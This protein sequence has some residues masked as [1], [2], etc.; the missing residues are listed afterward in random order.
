MNEISARRLLFPLNPLY[1]LGL[2]F[3]ELSL[4]WPA[5]QL[6]HPVVSIGNLSTG[7]S[8]K[9]PLTIALA[10]ALERRGIRV[11]VLSRGYGREGFLPARVDSEGCA[12]EF[13]DEP[14]LIAREAEVP[15]Y[16]APRRYDA[17]LLAEAEFEA[18]PPQSQVEE[19]E[20]GA[21]ESALVHE[22]PEL[23]ADG[24]PPASAAEAA[25][26]LPLVHLLDDG[27]Q[28]RQLARDVDIL[29]LNSRD[30]QDWLLPAGNLREPLDAARRADVIAIPA[31][32]P[33]LEVALHLWGWEKPIW[34]LQRIMEV[35]DVAGPVA[36]FCGIARPEQFFTGLEAAGV[37]IAA[38]FAFP[39]HFTYTRAALDELLANAQA[40]GAETLLTTDKDLARLGK[41]TALI[42]KSIS[43]ATARLRIKI[44][45]QAQAI[46]WLIAQITANSRPNH[47]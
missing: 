3:R 4:L 14:L 37:K 16:V 45:N 34:L 22:T 41:L 42:P 29:L 43:L 11:D 2:A 12:E 27:F 44:E 5:Q 24:N 26:P 6:G 7:G 40:A 8:G 10:G 28:H 46:D 13:G 33:E 30:W 35:P 9:T 47:Y 15:V 39:D 19:E 23:E 32:E 36:A 20:S 21:P 38:R 25:P 17:G 18:T 1:R 31:D